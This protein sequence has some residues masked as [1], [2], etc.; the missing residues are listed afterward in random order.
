M[1]GAPPCSPMEV[2][3]RV[4]NTRPGAAHQRDTKPLSSLSFSAARSTGSSNTA[5]QYL[6]CFRP[7]R[8]ELDKPRLR[9]ELRTHV[10]VR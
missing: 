3:I 6:E 10:T 1:S 9:C 8:T 4:A 2:A 5:E 7:Q